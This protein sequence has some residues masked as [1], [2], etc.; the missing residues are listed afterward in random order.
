MKIIALQGSPKKKGNTAKILSWVEEELQSMGHEVESIHLGSKNINGCL[1]C[2]K[3]KEKPDEPGCIQKDDAPAILENIITAKL[4][5]FATPIYFWGVTAQL[6]ALIDRTYSLYVNYHQPD[7]CSLLEGQHQALLATGGGPY[8]NN[9]EPVF[10]AFGR[11]QK[12]HRSINAGELYIGQCSTPDNLDDDV[13][14]RAVAF[15]RKI[16]GGI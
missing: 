1:A 14:K 10:T 6:K 3:C 7:H 12:P 2:G 5:I 16:A 4:L 11:L 15:A 8:E 13:K 9:A